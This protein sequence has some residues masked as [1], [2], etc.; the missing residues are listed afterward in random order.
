[1]ASHDSGDGGV[2]PPADESGIPEAPL[3]PAAWLAQN[4][5]F[6]VAFAAAVGAVWYFH[7]PAGVLRAGLVAL[8]LGLVI[9]VHELGHFLA[10]K[11]CDV[12]VKTFS[13]GFGPS[14][15]GCSFRSGE[16]TYMI[17]M[18][19]LGGYVLMVG[20]GSEEEDD[21]PRSFK[22]KTVFQRML[23]ISAGV[24]MNI[25]LGLFCML[26]VFRM[27]G[28]YRTVPTVWQLD[29]GGSAWEAGLHPGSRIEAIGGVEGMSFEDIRVQVALTG[30][31]TT[32]DLRL[33]K[34]GKPPVDLPVM[35]RRG[36]YD[37]NPVIGMTAGQSLN[38]PESRQVPQGK[39]AMAGTA[40]D[41]AVEIPWGPDA[42]VLK[43]TD[44]AQ[45]DAMK[46][47]PADPW[48]L[49][50]DL[51]MALASGTRPKAEVESSGGN[52]TVV[53]DG[54]GFEPGEKL[55]AMTDPDGQS[56]WKLKALADF[57]D[58]RSRLMR[59]AGKPIVVEVKAPD[60]TTRKLL[61]P[62]AYKLA[63]PATLTMGPVSVVRD[64][65]AAK[66]SGLL[67]G[68]RIT[69]MRMT[70]SDGRAVDLDLVKGTTD[71]TRLRG[72]LA[73][74]AGKGQ[75]KVEVWVNRKQERVESSP[76][77]EPLRM[78]WDPD[79]N[80]AEDMPMKPDSPQSIPQLGIGYR[81]ET[82]VAS[83][84][85]SSPLKAGDVITR[86]VW[87][88]DG[89]KRSP[90]P[91]DL[92]TR[93]PS[94]GDRAVT[95]RYDQGAWFLD[96]LADGGDGK[97]VSLKLTIRRADAEQA[98]EVTCEPDKSWAR[99]DRGLFLLPDSFLEKADNLIS[100]TR[101]GWRA[102]LK[103]M[104]TIYM[105]LLRLITRDLSAN[106]LGGPIEIAAQAFSA[107]EQPVEL[108]LFLGMISINLAVVNFLPIPILDGGHM[109]FLIYEAITRRPPPAWVSAAAGYL[110]LA[111]IL[112]L[113]ALVF[114]NDINRNFL[115]P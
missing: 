9:F 62:P 2:S 29:T 57:F 6:L 45:P 24:I 67:P 20:E 87:N 18:L 40:A 32:L 88:G 58:W 113:F 50:A 115:T 94:S 89:R 92:E 26:L 5:T 83:A 103:M 69:R 70:T 114:Y 49:A 37:P 44:P 10:A 3:S 65:S 85:E 111:I 41:K 101:L 1:M 63:L 60:D 28:L 98:V 54:K 105:N 107:A 56:P 79:W 99:I 7:G 11:W 80:D 109:V 43:I 75:A 55:A 97:S 53:L 71:P 8:G 91:A 35:P 77:P 27:H 68:D 34:P 47:A 25:L 48:K 36:P 95:S 21:S 108:V 16:T 51:A 15:P 90:K 17:G 74:A 64:Q 52:R 81:I 93:T 33:D 31:G 73:E 22:R 12:H 13:I 104:Q 72:A 39:V 84:P 106:N 30:S 76:L 78:D 110:G 46:E 66:K 61:V 42:R 23:I 38:L 112:S 19:P 82:I 59:L 86:A 96:R 4:S 102:T 100:A 14:L